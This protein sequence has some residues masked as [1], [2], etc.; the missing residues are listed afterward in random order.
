MGKNDNKCRWL[1]SARILM[2]DSYNPPPVYP[3]L[4]LKVDRLIEVMK[5]VT[6]KKGTL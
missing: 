5:E 1:K 3:D 2:I 6:R 4:E